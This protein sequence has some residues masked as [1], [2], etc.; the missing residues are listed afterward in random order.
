MTLRAVPSSSIKRL[1]GCAQMSVEYTRD[2]GVLTRIDSVIWTHLLVGCAV[3]TSNEDYMTQA[4]C[5][6]G[7]KTLDTIGGEAI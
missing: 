6:R 4:G 1:T 7:R 5:A 2:D 3:H